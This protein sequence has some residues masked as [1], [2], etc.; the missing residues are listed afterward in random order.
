MLACASV[1]FT[2]VLVAVAVVFVGHI[3]VKKLFKG[4]SK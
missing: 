4:E 2:F 1:A 3:L